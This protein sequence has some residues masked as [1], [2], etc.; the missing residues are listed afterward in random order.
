MDMSYQD[1]VANAVF[2]VQQNVSEEVWRPN[3]R[4][5]ATGMPKRY[6]PYEVSSGKQSQNTKKKI[7]I[8]Y[9][10]WIKEGS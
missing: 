3:L 5:W 9:Q 8:N 4:K 2:S 7:V 10:Q 6:L 1:R